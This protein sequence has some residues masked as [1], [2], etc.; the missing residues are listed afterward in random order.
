MT[1][2]KSKSVLRENFQSQGIGKRTFFLKCMGSFF[3]LAVFSL[4]LTGCYTFRGAS[5]DPNL[6]T[7]YIQNFAMVTAG[8]PSNL[9]LTFNEK[10]KEYY[11]RNTSLKIATINPD[12]QM[13]GGITGYEMTPQA[14]TSSDKAGLNR[15]T[16]RIQVKFTNN[17]DEA[18]NFDQEFSFYQDFPQNQTLSSVEG[19]L[20]P[21]ILDQIVLDIFNKTA[22]DW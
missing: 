6:K 2:K 12:L 13:E 9:S 4:L 20:Y 10:L 7:I 11:Q 16:I 19:Q 8:G 17:K 5:L 15:L 3:L 21:K 1:L 22:G 18:K 14:P